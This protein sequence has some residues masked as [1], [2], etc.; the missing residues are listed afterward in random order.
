M[1]WLKSIKPGYLS[2]Q[3]LG[4]P[5]KNRPNG[6]NRPYPVLGYCPGVSALIR[7]RIGP[8]CYHPGLLPPHGA[9]TFFRLFLYICP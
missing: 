5:Q 6:R 2:M 9:H 1:Q 7:S 3:M 8:Y 4:L